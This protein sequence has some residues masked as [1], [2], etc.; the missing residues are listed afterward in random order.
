MDGETE[1]VNQEVKI[2]LRFFCAKEQMKWKN[3]LHFAE[4]AHNSRTHSVTHQT[5]FYLTMGYHP[6]PLPTVFN[7]SSVPSVEQRISELKKLREE[8]SALLD[9][10]ARKIR[11]RSGRAFDKFKKGQKVWLEGKNLSLGYPS[12]KLSPKHE[13]PFKIKEVLG[14]V[15]YKLKLPFQWRIHPIFHAGLLTPYKENEIHG[16]N[17][18]EPPPDIVEGQEEHKVEAIIG[19]R[20]KGKRRRPT[21]YLVA[22]KEYDL[23]HN[24]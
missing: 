17:F 6:R 14:P 11:E 19:H 16:P 4:F 23:S 7:K 1:R 15:T 2:Y 5:P 21:E 12:P 18:L 8:T 13:G 9:I 24:Q 10:S 3:L 22:W 20:P